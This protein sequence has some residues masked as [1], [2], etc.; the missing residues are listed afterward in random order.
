M[1]LY[2][3][4]TDNDWF[5]LHSTNPSVEEVNFWRPSQQPY[6]NDFQPGMPFLFKLHAP[7]NYIVGGGFFLKFLPLPLSVA[8]E[9]FREGNG[10]RSLEELRSM[11]G[12]YRSISPTEDPLIGCTILG[13]P[14][15]FEKPDWISSTPYMKG[16]IVA[17]KGNFDA[18]T[19]SV[20]WQH[21]AVRLASGAARPVVRAPGPATVAAKE[22]ARYGRFTL[23]APRLGQGSFRALITDVYRYRCAFSSERT[24]PVLQAA[25]IRP[26]A[27]GGGHELSNGLLLRSDLHTLFD[28]HFMTIEPRNKTIVVSRRIREQF[29]NGRDYYAL[30]NRPLA[31]PAS[32]L[33]LPSMESLAYHFE[34]FSELERA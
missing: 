33:A 21:V 23:T 18:D 7:D 4:I 29:K 1:K 30:N 26:Y 25:H 28:Q 34:R 17:G 14:F 16:P 3:G 15:F 12:N 19:A 8:W 6:R 13:E 24:L 9:S 10:A 2:V 31:E 32:A 22:S 5:K 20:I 11:I 27:A